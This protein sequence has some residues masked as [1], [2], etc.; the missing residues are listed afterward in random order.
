MADF[1]VIRRHLFIAQQ[2][3]IIRMAELPRLSRSL[4][5]NTRLEIQRSIKL[6]PEDRVNL[7]IWRTKEQKKY[8][9]LWTI[10]IELNGLNYRNSVSDRCLGRI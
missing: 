3:E 7:Q 5:A 9:I 4:R 2:I 8:A 1:D 10:R 6:R